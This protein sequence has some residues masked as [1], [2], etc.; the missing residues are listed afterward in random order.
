[1]NDT[2]YSLEDYVADLRAITGE[3]TEDQKIV[4]RVRP[5]ARKLASTPG[6]MKDEYWKCNEEQGFSLHILHEEDNHDLAVFVASWLPDRGTLAHNHKTWAVVVGMHGQERETEWRRMDDGSKPGYAK[7]ERIGERVMTAG[8]VSTCMPEDIH[9]VWN[10][11][12][13]VAISLHTYGR[14]INFTG[15]SEFY[16]EKNEERPLTVTID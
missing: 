16:P 9:T 14:H 6:F 5:L 15:R 2:H 8:D 12:E 11:G 10:G 1:M 3:E 7:L 4:E 13:D